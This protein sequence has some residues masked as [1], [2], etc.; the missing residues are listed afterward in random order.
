MGLKRRVERLEDQRL[1]PKA[2]ICVF[3]DWLASWRRGDA[4]QAKRHA[5]AVRNHP[6]AEPTL[7]RAIDE[8]SER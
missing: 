5:D 8:V 6:D 3:V 7:E 2:A 1:G 4:E